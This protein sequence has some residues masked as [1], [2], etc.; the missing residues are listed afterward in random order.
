[1][2]IWPWANPRSR[3]S[4]ESTACY[5]SVGWGH[6]LV[7]VTAGRPQ[8]T[9]HAGSDDCQPSCGASFIIN[10]WYFE[11]GTWQTHSYNGKLVGN[12]IWPIE[13]VND[14]KR[15]KVILAVWHVSKSHLLFLQWR[16]L[17]Q[18]CRVDDTSPE[19]TIVGLL[20]S[21]FVDC[22]LASIPLS[23]VVRGRPRGLCQSLGG[24]S[25]TLT[26]HWWSCLESE[27]AVAKKVEPSCFNDT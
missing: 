15:L 3:S 4:A 8:Q 17:M 11:K 24:R 14:L 16:A 22:T 20:S 7:T 5:L 9:V 6:K 2:L 27:C 23:Q 1:M 13:A 21:W 26:A 19:N 18:C 10:K 25:D 12:H